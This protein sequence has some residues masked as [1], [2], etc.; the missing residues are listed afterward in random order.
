MCSTGEV[1]YIWRSVHVTLRQ[2][3]LRWDRQQGVQC[4]RLCLY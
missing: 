1:L 4:G 3:G 2:A